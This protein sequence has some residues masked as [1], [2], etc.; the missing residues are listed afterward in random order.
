[1]RVHG[2]SYPSVSYNNISTQDSMLDLYQECST[3]IS[4]IVVT[5]SLLEPLKHQ[6][7]L[8]VSNFEHS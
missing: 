7:R 8:Q 1:M 2:N 6:F 5:V 4:L 3:Y